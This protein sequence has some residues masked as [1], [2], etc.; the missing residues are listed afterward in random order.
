MSNH[1]ETGIRENANLS[2]FS[3]EEREIIN[4]FSRDWLITSGQE[5]DLA[6]S[7][8]K[9]VLLKPTPRYKHMFN[10]DRE[11]IMIFSPYKIFE[12]RSIDAIDKTVESVSSKLAALRTEEICSIII[13]EDKE[14]ESKIHS[15]LMN[16]NESKVIIPFNYVDVL[17]NKNN[18]F[19]VENKF[20]KY[21]YN[22]D[23]FGFRSAI[24]KESYFFGRR[25]FVQELVDKHVSGECSGI[26]G[27]RKTGK[28]SILFSLER[29]LS[30]KSFP[31]IFIDCQD[32]AVYKKKWNTLLFYLISELAKKYGI[33]LKT[34]IEKYSIE[35]ASESFTEDLKIIYSKQGKQRILFIFDEVERITFNI[36][37]E[38]HWASGADFRDFWR[39][40][41]GVFQKNK[42]MLSYLLSSTNP[43]CVETRLIE[44]YENPIYNQIIPQYIQQ[45]S[46]KQTKDMLNKLG[47]YMGMQF[48]D[49][50]CGNITQD[51]GGY[52]F[53]MRQVCSVIN[54]F[55][56][57]K[58]RPLIVD[59]IIYEK[60]KA[61]FDEKYGNEYSEMILE[62]LQKHYGTEF[63]LLEHLARGDK[64]FFLEHALSKDGVF[65]TNHL[66]GY[67]VIYKSDDDFD[68]KID[69]LKHYLAI[70]NKYKKLT[71]TNA[72]KVSEISVRRGNIEVRLRKMVRKLLF[73][74]YGEEDAK[75]K[76]IKYLHDNNLIKFN[77]FKYAELF[78]S[79]SSSEIK[80][81]FNRIADLM[82]ACWEECFRNIFDSDVEKFKA[83]MTLINA[84]RA[85]AHPAEVADHDMASFRGA[86]E[87][88]EIKVAQFED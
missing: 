37:D 3:S 9:A 50:V 72:E 68:F 77:K 80:L 88:L 27:L 21:F 13:S 45:F 42:N 20:R 41:R 58:Q 32:T 73:A 1:I 34:S 23:L 84:L 17:K 54:S 74:K 64:D 46:V 52:P 47:G 67:G 10:I 87:W 33:K 76:A 59:R 30:K 15:L 63:E 35:S 55:L 61:I 51:Y 31:S 14:I 48:D 83:R 49:I 43:T 36:S 12:P 44:G 2:Y 57:D 82:A 60:A 78:D 29:V 40:L 38:L 69:T 18:G 81:Y 6:N 65:Y 11:V 16:N 28:T 5:V 85:D 71:L 66:M 7:R 75:K 53:L 56:K 24:Q 62:V 86:M 19:Y 22:R 39:T 25:D 26:F 4:F 70:K 8:C 79:N